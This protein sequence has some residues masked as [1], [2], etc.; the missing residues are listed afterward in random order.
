M[1]EIERP[2]PKPYVPDLAEM[3]SI[4]ETNY[5]RLVKLLPDMDTGQGRR[6]FIDGG[7]HQSTHIEFSIEEQF[8][9][10]L[11]IV[12]EQTTALNGFLSAPKLEVRLY[13]DVRMAEVISFHN[14]HRFHGSYHYPNPK[15]RLPDEKLQI[16]HFLAEWLDHCLAHGETDISLIYHP[17]K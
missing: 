14:E 9:Y 10:T 3:A 1:T 2:K 15:M 5:L 17:H 4:C 12:A 11:T 8:K 16:N 7:P 13:H 6:F